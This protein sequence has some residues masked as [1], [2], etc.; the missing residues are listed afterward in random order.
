MWDRA[1]PHWERQALF[2]DEQLAAATEVLLDA[3]GIGAGDDVIEVAAGPGGVALAALERVGPDGSVTISDIA[4]GMVD[5]ARRRLGERANVRFLVCDQA[6]LPLADASLDAVISR[7]GLMFADDP[8]AAVGEAVRV[9]RP[10]RGFAAMT[11]ARRADNPWLGIVLDSVGEQFGMPFPPPGIPG[12]FSLDAPEE[13]AG[14]LER[15]GLRDVVVSVADT[16]IPAASLEVWW[17]RVPQ[18]AGPLGAL[19][20]AMEPETRDAIRDRALAS[21][22]SA[23]RPVDGGISLAGSSL[24]AAGRR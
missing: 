17:E 3:A 23:A 8:V 6:S 2:V 18:L 20:E 16:P 21:A 9:L 24:I 13:L 10:G 5:V 14:V 12:P 19:L 7:H 11:W 15:A 22:A 1:A 4:E